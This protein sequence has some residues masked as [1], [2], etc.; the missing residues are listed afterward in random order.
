[1]ERRSRSRNLPRT[2]EETA[3]L[4]AAREAFQRAKPSLEELVAGGEYS[5]AIK[6][7]EVLSMLALAA[8]I[9]AL[10]QARQLSLTEVATRSGI[11]KAQLSR[12]ENGLNA[13]PTLATLETIVRSLG[14]Q[15]RFIIDDRQSASSS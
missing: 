7:G 9:K 13:N 6:Q 5:P 15:L 14:A 8:Q 2:P 1:M 10:R 11:D 12:I 4:K 3:R